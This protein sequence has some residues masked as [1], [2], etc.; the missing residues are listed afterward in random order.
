MER[1]EK[2]KN[3]EATKRKRT[4]DKELEKAVKE[5]RA[6]EKDMARKKNLK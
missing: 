5:K 4:I 6:K 2:A 1:A 3:S